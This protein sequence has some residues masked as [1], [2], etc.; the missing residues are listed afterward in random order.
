MEL[1]GKVAVV[2]GAASGFGKGIA[3]AYVREGAQVACL[4][5]NAKGAEAVAAGL[6]EAARAFGCDVADGA[7]VRQA[8]HHAHDAFGRV[9]VVV[10]NAGVSHRNRPLLEVD[11]AEFDRVFAVNVKSIYHMTQA[12]LPLMRDQGGGAILN[13]GS[14]AGLRPRPGLTW[15]NGSKGAVNVLSKSMAVEL[16]ADNVRVNC[17]APVIGETALLE[18]FMGMP[19][20]PENRAK[21]VATIPMGR[22][23]RPEDV[24]QA[25]V[26][27]A[28]DRA[29]FVTGVVLEVDGGRCV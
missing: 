16:A 17:I 25:A 3:E 15:Y 21:F 8:V 29:G 22:L 2:T 28:S 14:T 20:T 5:L 24:A 9:D 19:D 1:Q 4:D 7:S 10:N 12:A 27:L 23:S 18:T 26:Y 6:G 13:V 11:E